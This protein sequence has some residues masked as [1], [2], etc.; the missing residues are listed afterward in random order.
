MITTNDTEFRG[1]KQRVGSPV[2]SPT[3][4]LMFFLGYCDSCHGKCMVT[5]EEANKLMRMFS[6]NRSKPVQR[7]AVRLLRHYSDY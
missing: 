1:R 7:V 2:F 5:N 3:G 4:R 6:R